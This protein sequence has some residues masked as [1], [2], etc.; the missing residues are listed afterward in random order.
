MKRLLWL[1]CPVICLPLL[2]GPPMGAALAAGES[3][4]D[5]AAPAAGP[6]ADAPSPEDEDP[7]DGQAL[8]AL[9]RMADTLAQAKGFSVTIRSNYDVVQDT[10]EKIEFGERRTVT[11]NRPD[12]LRVE[13]QQ[14]DGKKTQVT[15]DG[16]AITVFNPDQNVYGQV[17]KPGSVDDAVRY[18]VQD[19]QVRL[20]LALMLVTTL[21]AELDQRLLALDYVERDTLTPVPTDHLAGQTDEVDFQVWIA[22][23]GTPLPQRITITYK[24]DEGEPQ[25]RADLN[26]WTLN[27]QVPAA[28]IAFTPPQGAERIPF[29]VRVPRTPTG[30]PPATSTPPGTSGST[31][32]S[33]AGSTEGA[34]K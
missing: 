4:P 28:Q 9:M 29:L 6:S 15:Y 8:D 25:F 26:D 22:A 27:P 30:Q 11:L 21:P 2:L 34:A 19:L 24:N 32:G 33:T 13:S 14:S 18:V 17:E 23:E 12:G 3:P 31:A 5:S 20:P 1:S 16:K 10:G 7:I